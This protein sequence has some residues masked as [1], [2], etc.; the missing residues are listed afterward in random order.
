VRLVHQEPQYDQLL[1]ASNFLPERWNPAEAPLLYAAGCANGVYPCT[2]NNRQAMHP[3]TGQF[4][5]P[6]SV[7]NIGTIVPN[8]GNVTNALFL[9][10][11][12][13]ADTTY[14]WPALALAPRFGMAYD[15]TGE[16]RMVLRGG[17]GLFY[18]RPD[19]NAIFPQVQNPPT[20]KNVTVRYGQ[21]QSLG[22]GGLA[23]EG[24]P[25]LA[26]YKYD[27]KLPSSWQWNAGLQ[28]SL[29]WAVTLDTSYVGQHSFNTLQSVNLNAVDYG[30]AYLP[31]NQ[32]RSLPAPTNPLQDVL[33]ARAISQD[34]LRPYPGYGAITQQWGRGRRTFH[35]LQLSF[36]RRFQR[37]ISFGFND[38][39][40]WYDRQAAGARLQHNADGSFSLRPDQA[41]ADRL[42][43]N[44]N[45]PRHIMK[46]NFVWDLPNLSGGGLG[47]RLLGLI[48]NDW[49]FSGIWSG[50][51]F[52]P[53]VNPVNSAYTI[54]VSYQNGGGNQNLTGSPDHGARVHVV[55]DPGSGCSSDPLRQFNTSAFRGP[56]A[57]S[58]GLESSNDD[59]HTCFISYLDLAIARD[60]RLGGNRR[61]QL[62]VDLFNAMNQT[63]I[64]ARN[65][66]MNLATPNDPTTI[67]NLPFDIDGNVIP[68]RSRPRGAG[69]G[70]ATDYQ[71]PRR[72]QVQM[73]FSF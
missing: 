14:S 51:R 44:V 35:S 46:G 3:V 62:R 73:R 55:G 45:T 53:T 32:D 49:L 18:D 21:L 30:A 47:S 42:L 25:A 15:L 1:Q 60:I 16:Q 57:G 64:V 69:F 24:P 19:G 8:S 2:G 34:R 5:G 70:V 68:E 9:S 23:T 54:G 31:Q 6:N 50:G 67:T 66:T 63:G 29:P 40:T 39:F 12:G 28:S 43:G 52:D 4:L 20:Y 27:S 37:G 41:E 10:G 13:I 38:T 71:D 22:T 59:L 58:V 48:A 36:Q 11:Q 61:L 72:V 7:L 33:G 65:T 56:S 17:A 26:V